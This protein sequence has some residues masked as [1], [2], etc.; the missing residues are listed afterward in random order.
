M[1]Q[2][3]GGIPI[4][5]LF[6]GPGGLGEGFTA[7]R[8]SGNQAAFDVRLSIEKGVWAHQ[9]L[10]LRA[11]FRQF[12]LGRVP[13]KYYDVLRG[14]ADAAA[15]FTK[16]PEEAAKACSEAWRAE[17][18]STKDSEVG[19]RIQAALG[20]ERNWVL[21]GGPPCQAYSMAGRSRNKGIKGY[22]PDKDHRQY[23]YAEYLH[24][25]A[26]HWPAV[27]VMENVKGLLS[28][29]LQRQPVF[30]QILDDLSSPARALQR[31][32]VSGRAHRYTVV[33]LSPNGGLFDSS[34]FGDFVVQA[35]RHG[36]PQA[37]HRVILVGIRDDLTCA[38][39]SQNCVLPVLPEVTAGAVLDGLPRVRS[40]LSGPGPE[41]P[42]RWRESIQ[43]AR[44]RRWLRSTTGLAGDGVRQ[45]I[46]ETIQDLSLPRHDRGAE[47]IAGDFSPCYRADWFSDGKLEGVCNHSTRSH[48]LRDLHRY[49]YAACFAQE[50]GYSP[51]L[52]HFPTDLLPAHAN[53]QMALDGH[54]FFADRFRV[55]LRGRH[56]TTVTSHIAKDG[57]GFIHPDPRQCRSLTVR[58]AARLQ[59]F[60]DNYLFCGP[61]T[62]Q[63]IQVGNAVPPLLA[64]SIARVVWELLERNGLAG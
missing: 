11:F 31:R 47:F 22:R 5:D 36:I 34:R 43:E 24:I 28:A 8:A 23:L 13:A 4:I 50:H 45:R 56:S 19:D 52:R 17:L 60:P 25:I 63:Y 1:P 53:V 12:A 6:A 7:F 55:Q 54:G 51:T 41:T 10:T 58:E 61:R 14:R 15:L 9:T 42:E 38:N 30:E 32:S 29:T 27:F 21:I 33:S 62:E 64:Q 2:A 20:K 48:M 3:F 57:H 26:N 18:G 46:E 37:R 49:L 16:Y 35:E 39:L 59:T 44:E 40:A